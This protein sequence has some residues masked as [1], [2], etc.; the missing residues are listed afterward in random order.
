MVETTLEHPQWSPR[1]LACYIKDKRVYY[2]SESTVYRTLK[3]HDLVTSLVFNVITALDKFPHPTRTLNELWQ[4]DF[5]CRG[6]GSKVDPAGLFF[7]LPFVPEVTKV[8]I[9]IAVLFY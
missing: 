3:V 1:E 6:M 4:T 9:T 5:T 8:L 7:T 2:I